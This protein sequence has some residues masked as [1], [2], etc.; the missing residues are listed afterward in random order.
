V[1]AVPEES[2][3]LSQQ[4]ASP[5]SPSGGYQEDLWSGGEQQN[6]QRR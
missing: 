5:S 4:Y 1:I 3:K 2:V 6:E